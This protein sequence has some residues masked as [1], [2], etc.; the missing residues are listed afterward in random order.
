MIVS[1]VF[2]NYV[3]MVLNQLLFIIGIVFLLVALLPLIYSVK[4]YKFRY[5][6]NPRGLYKST[7]KQMY[8]HS[9]VHASY[10]IFR[11]YQPTE[12][13]KLSVKDML[14]SPISVNLLKHSSRR[15]LDRL[16]SLTKCGSIATSVV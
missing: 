6:P 3:N 12:F 11:K 1:I 9:D 5:D 2:S 15:E 7:V 4:S 16:V 8:I 10:N 13:A 14:I